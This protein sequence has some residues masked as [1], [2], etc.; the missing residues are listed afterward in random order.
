LNFLQSQGYEVLE[1]TPFDMFPQTAH[2]ETVCKLR[3]QR[4]E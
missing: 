3:L 2:I 1:V 4:Q